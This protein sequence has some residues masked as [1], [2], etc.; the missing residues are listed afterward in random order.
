[1]GESHGDLAKAQEAKA[2]AR[3]EKTAIVLE[4]RTGDKAAKAQVKKLREV[5]VRARLDEEELSD[6]IIKCEEKIEGLKRNYA[7]GCLDEFNERKQE[8]SKG[9]I[10]DAEEVD[11][12]IADVFVKIDKMLKPVKELQAEANELGVI[13]NF[14]YKLGETVGYHIRWKSWLRWGRVFDIV[15]KVY[16]K[17]TLVESMKNHLE[18]YSD[19]PDLR[20]V[21]EDEV[22]KADLS[23]IRV[24]PREEIEAQVALRAK[25][26]QEAA[27]MKAQ[28]PA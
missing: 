12:A 1:M 6:S 20:E 9:V 10:K 14:S 16:K 8:V 22:I 27:E 3:D 24:V 13:P 23:D 4:A 18:V 26:K 2:K 25:L 5:D 21:R 11:K 19:H 7:Q 28:V 15:H 17:D